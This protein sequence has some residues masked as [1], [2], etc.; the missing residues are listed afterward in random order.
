MMVE[1]GKTERIQ[2]ILAT[3]G[4]DNAARDHVFFERIVAEEGPIWI[5]L[6]KG[7][8]LEPQ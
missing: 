2:K 1:I 6:V 4:I 7:L 3:F 8:N 5:E